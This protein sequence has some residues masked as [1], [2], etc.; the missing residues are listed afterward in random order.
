MVTNNLSRVSKILFS[1]KNKLVIIN[2][3]YIEVLYNQ[4]LC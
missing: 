3:F 1:D 2:F 4:T